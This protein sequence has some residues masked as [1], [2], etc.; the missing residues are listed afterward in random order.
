MLTWGSIL[1]A[2]P[3]LDIEGFG[4][5]YTK[6]LFED[7]KIIDISMKYGVYAAVVEHK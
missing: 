2:K 4:L 6:P 7:G 3:E 5:H 1:K